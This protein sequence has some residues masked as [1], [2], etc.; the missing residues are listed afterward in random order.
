MFALCATILFQLQIRKAHSHRCIK[1]KPRRK[2][3]D[4]RARHRACEREQASKQS[5]KVPATYIHIYSTPPPPPIN[6]VVNSLYVHV[7]YKIKIKI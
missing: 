5:N 4:T 3:E 2:K 1:K 7:A 6:Y